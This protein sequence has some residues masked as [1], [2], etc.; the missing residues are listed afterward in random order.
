MRPPKI[1]KYGEIQIWSP[2]EGESGFCISMVGGGWLPG[3]FDSVE[4]ALKGS[5]LIMIDEFRF[6]K[7]IQEPTNHFDK[8]NREIT[9]EDLNV[10][11][12]GDNQ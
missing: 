10:T 6:V 7:E 4:S 9:I 11:W 5:E 12:E 2:Q 1:E 3:V 8:G